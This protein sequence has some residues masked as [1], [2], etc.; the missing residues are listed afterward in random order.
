VQSTVTTSGTPTPV[1]NKVMSAFTDTLV[2]DMQLGKRYVIGLLCLTLSPSLGRPERNV[3][4]SL[5]YCV[6]Q[7]TMISGNEWMKDCDKLL[8][9]VHYLFCL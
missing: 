1:L 6:L 3:K 7:R 8:L 2:T 5:R 9:P 4:K